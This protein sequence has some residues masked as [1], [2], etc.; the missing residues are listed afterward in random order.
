MNYHAHVDGFLA[1]Q[2]CDVVR[3][4]IS[5]SID[6]SHLPPKS[7]TC[8]STGGRFDSDLDVGVLS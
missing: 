5:R 7:S 8:N 3:S 2:S 1:T 6:E 4:Y